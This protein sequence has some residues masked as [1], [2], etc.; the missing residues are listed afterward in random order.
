MDA[1][2]TW[3]LK[4]LK[5]FVVWWGKLH[6]PFTHKRVTGKHYYL[7][8]DKINVGTVFLTTTRGEFSNLINPEKI[9]HAGIY[10]GDL[11]GDGIRYVV[12]ALGRGVV[13]TDLVTF[14]TTKDLVVGCEPNFL[15]QED[16]VQIPVEAKRILGIPYDYLFDKDGAAMYC[17]EAVAHIFKMVRPEIK[18]KCK[19]VVKGK[20][21]FSYE[22]YL[23]DKNL[24][25]VIF[26][27]DKV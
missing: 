18:L 10:V 13:K 14:L 5:P 12:E 11:D 25:E 19:E 6:V 7:L 8:R 27:S 24:F 1:I 22:T 17:F 26:E 16:K 4:V 2:Y 20:E 21:I 15:T 9:K 23:E 3:I